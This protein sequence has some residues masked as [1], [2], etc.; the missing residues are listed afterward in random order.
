[1]AEAREEGQHHAASSSARSPARGAGERQKT[2]GAEGGLPPADDIFGEPPRGTDSAGSPAEPEEVGSMAQ[3]SVRAGSYGTRPVSAAEG[4]RPHRQEAPGREQGVG[5]QGQSGEEQPAGRQQPHSQVGECIGNTPH[6]RTR[7]NSTP[8]PQ[9]RHAK[10]A[11]SPPKEQN[12]HKAEVRLKKME[13]RD[14]REAGGG[15]GK[16]DGKGKDAKSG[17]VCRF[18]LTD[19]G[20][21]KG[22]DCQWAHQVDDQKRCWNCGGKDHFADKCTRP[23]F[24]NPEGQKE[25]K[26]EGKGARSMKKKEED[27]PDGK[28]EKEEETPKKEEEDAESGKGQV[29]KELMEEANRMLRK[30]TK[31]GEDKKETKISQLQK[32]L[33][34][35]KSI[36]VL[37]L[38]RLQE[39]GARGLLDSTHPLRGRREGE[40]MKGYKEVTVSLAGGK[41][42]NLHV[43]KEGI[44]VAKN[45]GT[46]PI[47]PM[48][49]VVDLLGCRVAWDEDE[50][51]VMHR[52]KGKL[53]VV[54][55]G[56]CPEISKEDA[57]MLIEEIEEK[58]RSIRPKTPQE[59]EEEKMREDE[60]G[61]LQ[62]ILD[63]HPA[64]RKIPQGLKEKILEPPADDVAMCGNRRLRKKWANEGLILHLYAGP[65]EGYTFQRAFHE[66][67]GNKKLVLEVDCLRSPKWD[68]LPQGKAFPARLRL[69]LKGWIK[70]ILGGPNCRTRSVLRHRPLG[71]EEGE[72]RPLRSWMEDQEW[73]RNDFTES[74]KRRVEEDDIL[75]L[76]MVMLFIV[77]EEVRK[78]NSI[79]MPTQFALEQ[80]A[81]PREEEMVSWW[82]TPIW[83]MLVAGQDLWLRRAHVRPVEL[84]RKSPQAHHGWKWKLHRE[85]HKGKKR[86]RRKDPRR[87]A[88]RNKAAS[89][90]GSWHDES[91]GGAGDGEGV[92]EETPAE[93]A[94]LGGA[95]QGQP[96]SFQERLP[97]LPRGHGQGIPTQESRAC[98]SR[99]AI[100]GPHG[101]LQEGKDILKGTT[102]KFL[103]VGVYTWIDPRPGGHPA[104]D[105]EE[106]EIPDEA[107][108]FQEPAPPEGKKARGRPRKD[109]LA[110]K[111]EEERLKWKAKEG[112][113][114][115]EEEARR[116]EEAPLPRGEPIEGGIFNDT[117]EE[118]AA[119]V[120]AEE[121]QEEAAREP[122]EDPEEEAPD[123][124]PEA[125]EK[126][127]EDEEGEVRIRYCR[128]VLPIE[129][130]L[131]VNIVRAVQL[132]YLRLR[133]EGFVVNQIHTDRGGEFD[134]T[135]F[136]KWWEARAI[137]KTWT[138]GDDPQCNGRCERAVQEAKAKIRVMLLQAEL[139][140]EYWP[141]AARHLNEALQVARQDKKITWP[142]FWSRVLVRKRHGRTNELEPSQEM[143]NYLFRAWESHGHYIRD[144]DGLT[145]LSRTVMKNVHEPITEEKWIALEDET[146]RVQVRR[147]LRNKMTARQLKGPIEEEEEEE[148]RV[149]M[150]RIQEV[151][152]DEMGRVM[153]DDE[154]N[155]N[156]T[157]KE[158]WKLRKFTEEEAPDEVL[159]TK[160][161]G[162]QEVR[163]DFPK[164]KEAVENELRSLFETKGALRRVSP[165]EVEQRKKKGDLDV[166]PSKLVCTLKPDPTNP[167]GKRKIRIVAC[168]NFV[169]AEGADKNELFASG[170]DALAVR[171]AVD[172]AAKRGWQGRSMDIR[173]AFLN[174]PMELDEEVEERKLKEKEE[175]RAVVEGKDDELRAHR[176]LA[177][178]P[179]FLIQMGMAGPNEL[180]EAVRAFYGFHE[181]PRKWSDFRD[182]TMRRLKIKAK[183]GAKLRLEALISEPNPWKVKLVDTGRMTALLVVHVDDLLVLGDV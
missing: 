46:E 29:I 138:P 103:R 10:E 139:G 114:R 13:G 157:M 3:K 34:E 110:E 41:E 11:G 120:P 4:P 118:E 17:E 146:N 2:H 32:Q 116:R 40:K 106:V 125:E 176:V 35:L 102:A 127:E 71:D 81:V 117:D 78:A 23:S 113:K 37:R 126:Q 86:D 148:R 170:S 115:A 177:E 131:A 137:L 57:L 179:A 56:G 130:K 156:I 93:A 51:R 122:A 107:P 173:T 43:T 128:M 140:A 27:S 22:K 15:V 98:Q 85:S 168:G 180:W 39:G 88:E 104:P 20:C 19:Q 169:T 141:L 77:A 25:S 100:P 59:E 18:F 153:E 24:R 134:N 65:E 181:A 108:D 163:R 63:E 183:G 105:E 9:H 162:M 67:G 76:R 79:K 167:K 175:G 42:A 136:Q 101:S 73:G 91:P 53:E 112:A 47:V 152:R 172:E 147:R 69:A 14:S 61:W 50:V 145:R 75:M 144:D 48:G 158:L 150:R 62:R 6:R 1:M 66:V 92:W 133:S 80:P 142:P 159:Q 155:V 55:R 83:K 95:C 33:D 166:I 151:I 129:T 94:E 123:G 135:K 70:M 49:M 8:G 96:H 64:F 178:P 149:K 54:L 111:K 84:G 68:M 109:E 174:A 182:F 72:P 36:K 38:A 143:V 60:M 164:W 5:L 119:R 121:D 12:P 31:D 132:F 44:M 90:M 165:G 58:V 97:D 7:T 26:G 154:E 16:G 124:Q 82:R 30:I 28:K 45:P 74:E 99:G 21:K 87:A 52:R 89:P 161:V 160:V 171:L